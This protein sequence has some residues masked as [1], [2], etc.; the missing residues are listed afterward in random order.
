M[1]RRV[2]VA[3][4][5]GQQLDRLANAARLVDAALLADRLM[6]RQV[7]KRVATHRAIAI[8]AR[9]GGFGIA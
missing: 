3:A 9:H 7:Q 5:R 6:H 1:V 4:P 8:V 2:Q